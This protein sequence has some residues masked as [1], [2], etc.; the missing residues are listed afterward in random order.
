MQDTARTSSYNFLRAAMVARFPVND[1]KQ[2]QQQQYQ[3]DKQTRC[4]HGKNS[5][6]FQ[7]NIIHKDVSSSIHE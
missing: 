1:N 2:Q 7:R 6:R 4:V 3:N 5:H